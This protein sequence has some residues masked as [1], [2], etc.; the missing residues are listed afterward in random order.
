[1]TT[2]RLVLGGL[3][4]FLV[5][6]FAVTLWLTPDF[7]RRDLLFGVTVAPNARATPAGRRILRTYRLGIAVVTVVA[8]A[9]LALALALAPAEWWQSGVPSIAVLLIFAAYLIP[10]L[11]AYRASRALRV[12]PHAEAGEPSVREAELRSRHYGDDVPLVWELLPIA[13]IV[14]TAA[15]LASLYP[16]APAIIPTH[17]SISG[18][19]NGFAPKSL[20]SFFALVWTQLGL[21]VLLTG[22]S[23]LVV[24]AKTPPGAASRR[25][26]RLTLRFLFLLK[27]LLLATLGIE[28]AIVSRAAVLGIAAPSWLI[29]IVL[30]PTLLMVIGFLILA[31]RI[32]QGGAKLENTPATQIDRMDDRYWLL[33]LLYVNRDDPSLLVQRRFGYG[34]T[35]NLGNLWSYVA[36]ALVLAIPFGIVIVHLV[37]RTH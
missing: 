25:F 32:G 28:A 13:L 9:A 7:T 18:T 8:L 26:L 29:W 17:W 5:L 19:P 30:V 16:S 15:Y 37:T 1:M 21:Y 2:A 6:F 24:R 11:L 31:V 36:L 23:V 3:N 34:W 22:I 14:A 33:G 12:A 20:A 10:Y 35:L 4:V 27:S